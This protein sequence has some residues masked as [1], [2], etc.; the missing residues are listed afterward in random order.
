MKNAN[1]KAALR[2]KLKSN[3]EWTAE[4]IEDIN[5]NGISSPQLKSPQPTAA[6]QVVF[7]DLVTKNEAKEDTME[8]KIERVQV[9][10]EEAE[11]RARKR[12]LGPSTV[13]RINRSLKE[14]QSISQTSWYL[15]TPS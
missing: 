5:N 10:K 11:K 8:E 3:F 1:K 13:V 14:Y 7:P 9:R 4:A 12:A 15:L 2:E 6:N